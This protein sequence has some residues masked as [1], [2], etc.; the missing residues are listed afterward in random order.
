MNVVD[1]VGISTGFPLEQGHVTQVI[2]FGRTDPENDQWNCEDYGASPVNVGGSVGGVFKDGTAIIC[3]GYNGFAVQFE[4]KC[5]I[6]S[7]PTGI[8]SG[9]REIF[10]NQP[11]YMAASVVVLEGSMLFIAGGYVRSD[12]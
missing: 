5:H 11:R 1:T 6:L 3:G 12:G 8:N 7:P 4:R 2:A 10:M 9:I